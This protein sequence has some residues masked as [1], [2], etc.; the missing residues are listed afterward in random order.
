MRGLPGVP[1]KVCV[2]PNCE[3]VN[4]RFGERLD[5]MGWTDADLV[6]IK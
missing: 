1:T 2:R 6:G 4:P 3:A 5:A